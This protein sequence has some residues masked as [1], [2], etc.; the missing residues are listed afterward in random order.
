MS[1][2]KSELENLRDK[3]LSARDFSYSPYSKF[4]VGA[5]LLTESGEWI[6]GANVE[7]ASYGGAICAERVAITRAIMEGHKKFKA[8]G[9]AS[10]LSVVCSPCGICRQFIREWSTDIP[11]YLFTKDGKYTMQTI[12]E[13]L[14]LSFG[15]EHL[16]TEKVEAETETLLEV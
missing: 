1:I 6:Q 16:D 5:V 4:R 3:S 12:K 15:P 10:D 13:L 11:I 8:I 7:N 9:V 14:P 2:T